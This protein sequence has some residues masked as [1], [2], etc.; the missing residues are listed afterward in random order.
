MCVLLYVCVSTV[1]LFFLNLRVFSVYKV[2]T[3]VLW[4]LGLVELM[5]DVATPTLVALVNFH[6]VVCR[7]VLIT[8][9]S[10]VECPYL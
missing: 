6:Y 4:F 5:C 3:I 2:S 7:I 8:E 1:F 10:S 9:P